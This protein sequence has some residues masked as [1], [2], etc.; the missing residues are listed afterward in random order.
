MILSVFFAVSL[1]RCLFLFPDCM[2]PENELVQRLIL[3]NLHG[4]VKICIL[5]VT[6]YSLLKIKSFENFLEYSNYS[7]RMLK[8]KEKSIKIKMWFIN[9]FLIIYVIAK[10]FYS[11]FF[12]NDPFD[13]WS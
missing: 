12:S 9:I 5:M 3:P 4:F 7:T 2:Y 10:I 13:P 1:L 6:Y 11:I 8:E